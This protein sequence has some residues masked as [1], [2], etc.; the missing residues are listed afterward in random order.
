M[1][2]RLL[3]TPQPP[4]ETLPTMRDLPSQHPDDPGLPDVFHVLQP[5]VLRRTCR[6]PNCP[7]VRMFMIRLAARK[8]V[9]ATRLVF[10]GW[11][12]SNTTQ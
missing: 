6:S 11:S 4:K 5:E 1:L 12:R 9:Q 7:I 2:D 3:S 10:S 8:M